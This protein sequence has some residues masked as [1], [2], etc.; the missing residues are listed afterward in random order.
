MDGLH[1]LEIVI[2]LL[3]VVLV[4]T[5]LAR[6]SSSFPIPFYWSSVD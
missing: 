1:Q 5:T 6:R 3:A 4:L 2:L